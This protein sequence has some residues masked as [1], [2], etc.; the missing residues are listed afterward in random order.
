[1]LR[2]LGVM[3]GFRRSASSLAK[4]PMVFIDNAFVDSAGSELLDVHFPGDGSVIGN[5]GETHADDV[6]RAIASSR[7]CFDGGWATS[8][9]KDRVT[10]LKRVS[11]AIAEELDLLA[12]EESRESGK[13]ITEAKADIQV[14]ADMFMYYAELLEKGELDPIECV[15]P[16]GFTS[17]VVK[18]PVGVVGCIT[19]WNYPLMQAVVKVAPAI[20]SGSTVVLKPSPYASWTCMRLGAIIAEAGAPPGLLNVLTGNGAELGVASGMDKLSFTGSGATGAKLLHASADMLRP[21]S[22]E[23][24][25]KGAM[26]IFED[27]NLDSVVDWALLGVFFNAGQVCSA[28]SRLIIH[29]DIEEELLTRM[30][31]G[32]KKLVVGDPM[33]PETQ[34]GPL[35]SA[36]QRDRVMEFL[37][38]AEV[39]KL[40]LVTGGGVPASVDQNGYFVEPTIYRNVPTTSRLWKEEIFGPVLVTHTF[41][42]EEEAV[43]LMNDTALGLA[44]SIMTKDMERAERVAKQSNSGMVWK[45]SSQPIFPDTPFGGKGLSGFGREYGAAGLEEYLSTKTVIECSTDYTWNWYGHIQ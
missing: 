4:R 20:A 42:T 27:V 8:P 13:P 34:L 16:E 41:S 38:V 32:A 29:K 39:E 25:G 22:L 33:L 17:R 44:N 7:A 43:A 18:E 31:A 19:P 12:V 14:C 26:V 9:I 21:T 45:N 36:Q 11:D 6:A 15:S 1:M 3:R 5:I 2:G 37:K 30:I 24:G 10:L 40:N 35:V 28:T 23:L